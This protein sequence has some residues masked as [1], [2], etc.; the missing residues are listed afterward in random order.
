MMLRLLRIVLIAAATMLV[1]C[2]ETYA[3]QGQQVFEGKGNCWTCHGRDGKGTPLGPNLTDGEWLN[4]D[5]SLDSIRIVV[6]AGV[7]KP[8]RYPAPMPPKGGA[9]L[10]QAEI[11]AV[12]KYVLELSRPA[13][14]RSSAAAARSSAGA[15]SW[16]PLA[17]RP[18]LQ[19]AAQ[20]A[21]W[22]NSSS[23]RAPAA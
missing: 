18:A 3:Q 15:A 9:K 16:L 7:A 2:A 21:I 20:R 8:K 19:S 22:P 4:I 10:S 14:A 5:G 1:L 12:S 13:T 11:E 23:R 6:Q 17:A